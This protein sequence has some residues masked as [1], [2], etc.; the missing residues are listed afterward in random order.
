MLVLMIVENIL[1]FD[2]SLKDLHLSRCWREAELL[3]FSS[4]GLSNMGRDL[5]LGE[6][7]FGAKRAELDVSDDKVLDVC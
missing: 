2:I 7:E 4:A 6:R 3:E 5:V 1:T